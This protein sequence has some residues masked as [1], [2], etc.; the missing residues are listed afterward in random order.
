MMNCPICDKP[1]LPA[2]QQPQASLHAYST[3]FECGTLK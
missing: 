1:A 2:Y 3:K